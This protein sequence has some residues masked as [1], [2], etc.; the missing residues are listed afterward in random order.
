MIRTASTMI[1]NSIDQ[2]FTI[3]IEYDSISIVDIL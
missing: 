2:G 1:K 3:N